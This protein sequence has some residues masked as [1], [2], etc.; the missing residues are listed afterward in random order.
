[1]QTQFGHKAA[2]RQGGFFIAFSGYFWYIKSR[3]WKDLLGQAVRHR[4]IIKD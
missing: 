2:L 4:K 1:M 3:D